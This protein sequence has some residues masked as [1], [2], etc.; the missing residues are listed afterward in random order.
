MVKNN[1]VFLTVIGCAIIIV[2]AFFGKKKLDAM[3]RF[4]SAT[5]NLKTLTDKNTIK[6]GDLI[7]QTSLSRQ[8]MAV[9][10]ATHSPYSHCG[11][12]FKKDLV[13]KVLEAVQPVKYTALD[14][15]MAKGREGQYIIRRLKNSDKILT[16]DVL[17][18]LKNEAGKFLNKKYD[19][20]FDW[21][22]DKMY[23][24]ELIWK[25]YKRGAGIEIGKLQQLKDFDLSSKAV[26]EKM[27][28]RYGDKIPL[29]DTVISPVSIFN[30]DLL[31]TVT[32]E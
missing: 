16:K 32:A 12:I 6:E 19:I 31:E 18:K 21:S 1:R 23:C 20:Y 26:K 13:F 4:K 22:D 11:I 27:K 25:V 7:F 15:W 28:E 30:S 2:G 3:N 8:S 9:Q 14:S 10:L 29:N 5:E 17:E 24:S